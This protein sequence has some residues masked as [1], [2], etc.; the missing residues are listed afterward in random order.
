MDDIAGKEQKCETMNLVL[1][2][3]RTIQEGNATAVFNMINGE[4]GDLRRAINEYDDPVTLL[5]L[6]HDK[7]GAGISRVLFVYITKHYS[8]NKISYMAHDLIWRYDTPSALVHK[9]MD[10]YRKL[11]MT[12]EQWN[13]IQRDE[14]VPYPPLTMWKEAIKAATA[15]GRARAGRPWYRAPYLPSRE[16]TDR[17]AWMTEVFLVLALHDIDGVVE[18]GDAWEY[19]P[20]TDDIAKLM[21]D[22]QRNR[23]TD[24]YD[25]HVARIDKC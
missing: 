21:A 23:L 19:V 11:A 5:I 14:H 13:S 15:L 20:I 24:F 3:R 4:R 9:V 17:H 18:A 25:R 2:F 10:R 1:R 6:A 7:L 12:Y 22:A 16:A 8:W